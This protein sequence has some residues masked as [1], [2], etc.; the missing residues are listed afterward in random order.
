MVSNVIK[1][2]NIPTFVPSISLTLFY[3]CIL[4]VNL[5]V[6]ILG[7]GVTREQVKYHFQVYL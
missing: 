7:Y 1:K 4:M 5:C 2:L 6:N 3:I